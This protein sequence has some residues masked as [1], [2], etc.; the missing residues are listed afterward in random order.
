MKTP[1]QHQS[2]Y[3]AFIAGFQQIRYI[4]FHV[5]LTHFRNSCFHCFEQVIATWEGYL[6]LKT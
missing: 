1:E 6:K 5:Y 4:G 2:C 3:S